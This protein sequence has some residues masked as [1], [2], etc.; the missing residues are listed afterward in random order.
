MRVAVRTTDDRTD[1]T[2]DLSATPHGWE[3]GYRVSIAGHV[4][5]IGDTLPAPE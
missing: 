1:A 3:T 4:S 5:P 2:G